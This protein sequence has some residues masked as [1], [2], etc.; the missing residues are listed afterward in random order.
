MVTSNFTFLSNDGKTKVHAVKW[1]PDS[2]EYYAILQI[3]HGMVEYIE[4]YVPFAEY[5]TSRGYMIVGHDHI[6]HGASVVSQKDWGYFCEGN[7]SDILVA[8]MH[9]LRSLIQEENANIP[10][11]ILGHSM[12]SFLLR[13][14]LAFYHEN[15]NGAIIMGT[16]FIPPGMTK[17]ALKLTNLVGYIRGT[18]YRSKFIS[19]LTFGASYKGF[20]MSGT[21]PE[22]SWLTKDIE[23]VKKYYNEPRCTFLFTL[24]G[25][26]GLF[27]AVD[28]SCN[29]E[30]IKTLPKRLPILIVSGKDDP[31][32]DMGIGVEKVYQMFQ[33]ADLEDVVCKL[34]ENDRHEILNETDREQVFE[35]IFVWLQNRLR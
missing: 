5:L 26:K 25:Y 22:K 9:K 30:N 17:L 23:I 2:G 15:L 19:N 4:R 8:D 18:H 12:G 3:S 16:G 21:Q 10:Y 13:K 14:Y 11:F 33:D 34:Y 24:N 32:G 35:D 27:E 7:P 6:G 20:D 1:K 31:V 28:F 29:I